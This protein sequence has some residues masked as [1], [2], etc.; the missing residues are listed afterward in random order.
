M[1]K[2][3]FEITINGF[4][5]R[6]YHSESEESG[7]KWCKKY[8]SQFQKKVANLEIKLVIYKKEKQSERWMYHGK[9]F[10]YDRTL[11]KKPRKDLNT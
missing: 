3:K 11:V 6:T 5:L 1:S 7:L 10:L 9:P 2:Y 4:I 8:A